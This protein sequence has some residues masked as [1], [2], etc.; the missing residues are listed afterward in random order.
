MHPKRPLWPRR[1]CSDPKPPGVCRGRPAVPLN[2]GPVPYRSVL[3]DLFIHCPGCF[4]ALLASSCP[5]PPPTGAPKA[6]ESTGGGLLP[7]CAGFH[8]PRRAEPDRGR[9]LRSIPKP[10]V[11]RGGWDPRSIPKSPVIR[12]GRC[13]PVWYDRGHTAVIRTK[14]RYDRD[15]P[16]FLTWP[17]L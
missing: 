4:A 16:G 1:S 13:V 11:I 15:A 5:T 6:P 17:P 3:G 14:A 9:D 8:R 7:P 2:C 12:D 10:P